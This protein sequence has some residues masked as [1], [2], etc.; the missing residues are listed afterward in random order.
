M[1]EKKL[2]DLSD[3]MRKIDI[4]M[5]STHSKGGNIAGRPMSN[6]GEVEYDGTSYY[7]TYE[8]AH[9]VGEIEAD[10]KVALAFMGEK[11]FAVAVEG[12]AKLSRDKAE[13]K[14]HWSPDLDKWFK[15]G[16]DTPDIVM[17]Q[18]DATRVHYWDGEDEGEIKL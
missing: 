10:P 16:I 15:D 9:T 12:Q 17:I 5:L 2:A 18:V 1:A 7:F 11:G 14:E 4:A 8:D 6:N 13:M 3:Q